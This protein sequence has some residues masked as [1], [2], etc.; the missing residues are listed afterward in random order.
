MATATG[1]MANAGAAGEGGAGGAGGGAGG[2]TGAGAG[3][4]GAAG[5]AGAGGTDKSGANAGVSGGAG[6]ANE[7]FYKGWD[8]DATNKDIHDWVKNKAYPDVQTLARSAHGL[9]RLIGADRAGRVVALPA[10]EY[11][12]KGNLVKEDKEGEAA[13]RTKIG[14]PVSAD[15]YDIPLPANN[16]Y[17]QF[18]NMMADVFFQNGVP[19]RMATQLAKGYESAIQKMETEV[20]AQEDTKSEAAMHEL[21][22]A[23]GSD[24]QE[25]VNVAARGK[26]WL[27]K[28]SGGLNDVQLRVMESVLGTS[29]FM[30]MMWK[31]GAGNKEAGFV[32]NDA[33]EPGSFTGG[34]AAA[35]SR[36]DQITAD[37]SAG[38]IDDH[39]WRTTYEPEALKLR[40]VIIAGFANQGG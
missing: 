11:D 21:E 28:E 32:G 20:R 15:K 2:G 6:A 7:P 26:A 37:R 40:D 38:K 29:N 8:A 33:K 3:G 10:H 1:A 9:E 22:R 17:P 5:G 24:Y 27:A 16:P 39:Q 19:A 14:V 13:W 23:W 35:Q 4:S 25:R 12:D 18:K 36:L 30:T 34:A 31:I